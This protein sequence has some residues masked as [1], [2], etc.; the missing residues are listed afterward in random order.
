VWGAA[1]QLAV[2]LAGLVLAGVA[3]L[4]VQARF[5]GAAP[6]AAASGPLDGPGPIGPTP[7]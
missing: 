1:L 6:R 5:T 3:T 2:N 4:T 7:G